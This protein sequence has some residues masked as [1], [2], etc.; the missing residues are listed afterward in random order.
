MVPQV[1]EHYGQLDVLINNAST[2]YPTPIGKV[3][4]NDWEDLLGTKLMLR[5]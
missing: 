4:E 3:E 2:F 5:T 1:I